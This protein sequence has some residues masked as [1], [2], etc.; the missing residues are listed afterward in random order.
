MLLYRLLNESFLSTGRQF[1]DLEAFV[2]CRLLFISSRSGLPV[3]QLQQ[4]LLKQSSGLLCTRF[5]SC[6][7]CI[8]DS[9]GNVALLQFG[10][11]ERQS[12]SSSVLHRIS[13]HLTDMQG[14]L[15]SCSYSTKAKPLHLPA[16]SV[17][18]RIPFSVP[19][20][21]T[22][23]DIALKL[24]LALTGSKAFRRSASVTDRTRF[25]TYSSF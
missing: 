18:R 1:A 3:D 10:A 20:Y 8:C 23:S 13:R 17:I 6:S 25:A 24:V 12:S 9:D 4:L 5:C 7:S 19:Y 14:K 21:R 15:T 16:S 22:H 2:S 11:I